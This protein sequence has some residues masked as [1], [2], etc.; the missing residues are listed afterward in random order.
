MVARVAMQYFLF[1]AGYP[2]SIEEGGK[3]CSE[4]AQHG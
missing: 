3:T 1:E 4:D 2:A